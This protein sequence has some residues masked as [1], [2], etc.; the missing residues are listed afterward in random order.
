MSIRFITKLLFFLLLGASLSYAQLQI[1]PKEKKENDEEKKDSVEKKEEGL[2]DYGISKEKSPAVWIQSATNIINDLLMKSV[3]KLDTIK[4]NDE[5]DNFSK[6]SAIIMRDIIWMKDKDL[7]IKEVKEIKSR[8]LTLKTKLDATS[9]DIRKI[10]NTIIERYTLASKINEES[11]NKVIGNDTA[12]KSV[13]KEESK[14][15][16]ESAEQLKSMNLVQMKSLTV[17]ENKKNETAVLLAFLI[18]TI[19]QSKANWQKKALSQDE[20]EFWNMFGK[21]YPSSAEVYQ[22]SFDFV[23][24]SFTYYFWLSWKKEMTVKLIV[25]V[26]LVILLFYVFNFKLKQRLDNYGKINLEYVKEYPWLITFAFLMIALP[27]ILVY[28]PVIVTQLILLVLMII[29][30]VIVYRKFIGKE[31]VVPFFVMFGFYLLIK[32]EDFALNITLL[33]RLLYFLMIVPA[34][35]LTMVLWKNVSKKENDRMF[36][37][38]LMV[39]L[40]IHFGT[41]FVLNVL[42]WVTMSKIVVSAG[43]RGYYLALLLGVG[44]YV[45]MDYILIISSYFDKINKAF[46]VNLNRIRT[47]IILMLAFF[48]I[49]YWLYMYLDYLYVDSYVFSFLNDAIMQKRTIGSATFSLGSVLIFIGILIFAFYI[50]GMIKQIIEVNDY[51]SKDVQ[52]SNVG[53]LLLIMRLVVIALG[54]LFALMASGIPL[55]TLAILLSALSVG[56]GFGLQNI[57]NNLVS[58]VIIA[59]ERPFKV[60]DIVNFGGV[61]GM[62]KNI[63]VRSSIVTSEEGSELIIPNGDLISRNLINWTSNNKYRKVTLTIEAENVKD[64]AEFTKQIKEGIGESEQKELVIGLQANVVSLGKEVQ[65]WE[66]SFWITDITKH[67]EIRSGVIKSVDERLRKEGVKVVSFS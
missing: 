7:S 32:V 11:F 46:E 3:E 18:E 34:V 1:G 35:Y 14:S 26:M 19:N 63:G 55:D 42:G 62:V 48:A 8:L 38:V 59:V 22:K 5:M 39:F 41:G 23:Y 30:T 25:S 64:D 44:V 15:L 12:L 65:K 2:K 28:P 27:I 33:Q 56:I 54:F 40:I 31:L 50:A 51:T 10:S 57:I 58:G 29:V 4:W 20:P 6:E 67:S 21:L 17:R 13:F 36:I 53:G 43:L 66:I 24:N 9:E 61:D 52:R 47:K 49:C 45:V 16:I 37:K 60:G